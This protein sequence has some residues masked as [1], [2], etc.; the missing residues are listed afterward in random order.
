M[1]ATSLNGLGVMITRPAHQAT[2]LQQ[3][4]EAAGG[5]AFMYPMLEI[6]P[7][8]KTPQLMAVFTQLEQYQIIIFI[9]PNAVEYGL[10]LINANNG[11]SSQQ[12][13]AA[14]GKGTAEKFRTLTGKDVDIMPEQQFNSEGL[15]AIPAM[16]EVQN[17][18]I[19]IMRGQSGRE[20]LADTL[21]QRGAKVNYAAVYRRQCPLMDVQQ[22][23]K[24]LQQ[25]QIGIISLTSTEAISNLFQQVGTHNLLELPY[26][27]INTRLAESL[28]ERGVK[29]EIL[30]SH[31]ASDSGILNRLQQ[32]H[33]QI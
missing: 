23:K 2:N 12:R 19:L 21:Q 27:V 4:I 15:L 18:H 7:A 26:L 29:S 28:K 31:E 6:L 13:I 3:Q 33:C 1:S 9:S 8:D 11:L 14:V 32:W 30:V 25:G 22:L 5:K 16:Q 17:Q 24:D 10:E 20:L